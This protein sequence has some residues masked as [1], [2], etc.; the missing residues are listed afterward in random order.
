MYAQSA[1]SHVVKYCYQRG[2]HT[3]SMFLR[4]MYMIEI[5]MSA[6]RAMVADSM[7][8]HLELEVQASGAEEGI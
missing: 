1:F 3:E 7:N 8:T 4:L 5:N 6:Q 2:G